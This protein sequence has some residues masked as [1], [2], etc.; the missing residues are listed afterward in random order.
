MAATGGLRWLRVHVRRTAE[1]GGVTSLTR[2]VYCPRRGAS[3]SV[4]D[5]SGCGNRFAVD[6]RDRDEFLVCD[7]PEDA[8]IPPTE[9]E[10]DPSRHG[11]SGDVVADLMTTDVVCVT[12]ELPVRDLLRVFIERS[13]SGA[14]VV[15][16]GKV[17][18]VVTKTDLVRVLF[19]QSE[20]GTLEIA[21]RAGETYAVAAPASPSFEGA[22]VADVM[23]CLTLTLSDVT[24]LERAAAIM[25]YEGIHRIPVV[26]STDEVVGLLTSID[27]LRWVARRAGYVVPGRTARQ[28]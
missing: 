28:R 23:T 22:R 15:E 14:P 9:V 26:S 3:V 2:T 7:V 25:A 1:P 20:P 10:P 8:E 6:H 27:V 18:G 11:T 13:I 24:S 19:Q 4:D 16:D 5:C 17:V 21:G 12:P